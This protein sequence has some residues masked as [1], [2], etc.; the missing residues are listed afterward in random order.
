M[1]HGGNVHS[2]WRS[3]TVHDAGGNDVSTTGTSFSVTDAALTDT[4][5]VATVVAGPKEVAKTNVTLMTFTDA[6]PFAVAGDFSVSSQNFGGTLAGTAPTLSIVADGS[7]SGSGTGWKVVADTLTYRT[8]G[9]YNVALTVHDAG[10]NDVSTTGTSFSMT[11]A[12]VTDT[13]PVATVGGTGREQHGTNRDADD[14]HRCQPVGALSGDYSVSSQNVDWGG[15]V[16]GTPTAAVQLVS[17]SASNST[18][19]VVGSAT[20]AEPGNYTVSVTVNDVD[21]SSVATN[22]TQV[23]VADAP[24]TD[25][26]PMATVHGGVGTANTNVVLMTFTDANPFAVAGDFSISSQNF[27]GTLAGT[28]PTL[29]VLPDASYVGAGSGWKVVADTLTYAGPGIYNVA[30]AVQ[31]VGGSNVSTNNTT[32]TA[33]QPLAFTSPNDGAFTVGLPGQL[34][35]TASGFP[36]ATFSESGTDI[37]PL[38]LMLNA[39]T[40]V[41]SGIPAAGTGGQYNLHFSADNIEGSHAT[42]TVTLIT[43]TAPMAFSGEY[44]VSTGA[45]PTTLASIGQIGSQLTLDGSVAA[46]A[47]ITNATQL[48]VNGTNTASYGNGSI[49]FSSGPLAGQV[50]TKIVLP[51]TFTFTNRFGTTVYAVQTG[52]QVNFTDATGAHSQGTWISSTQ[53]SA[54]GETV[55]IGSGGQLLWADGSVWSPSFVSSGTKNLTT[56]VT[57]SA[58]A[59][60]IQVA[61][62]NNGRGN[63]VYMITNGSTAVAIIDRFGN[64]SV[65]T[66]F[67]NTLL[68]NQYPNDPATFSRGSLTWLDGTVWSPTAPPGAIL[69]I[70]THY[71]NAAGITT[72][73]VQ[74][75]SNTVLFVDSLG[76]M[77][78]ATFIN[79]TQQVEVSLYPGDLATLSANSVTWQDG[80]VWTATANPPIKITAVDQSTGGVSHLKLESI[81]TLIGLDGP[82]QGVIGTRLDDVIFWS[83]R[84]DVWSNF[85]DDQIDALFEMGLGYQ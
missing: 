80:T 71:T 76:R 11:D 48:L 33:E 14:V 13:T 35:L 54:Y 19:Q 45:G 59:N 65:G 64:V 18:W 32:I 16:I 77:S 20:Y 63:G 52:A 5:P 49:T 81:T 73:T 40:G 50:W 24:L 69:P 44:S 74:S 4:T 68:F 8:A 70:V 9:T 12:A 28:S 46:T 75:N 60:Q 22:D 21:G 41:L 61:S 30:L 82:L 6:N 1:P 17:Q 84:V 42:Q 83:R 26:T 37:L 27:G 2:T 23:S 31:D 57:I 38:G 78:V 36:A 53:L 43:V 85:S 10:G 55:T 67:G 62:F 39:A 34:I 25:T 56:P 7:F 58:I 29:S 79:G 72:H 15:T 66:A 51:P 47:T 3:L